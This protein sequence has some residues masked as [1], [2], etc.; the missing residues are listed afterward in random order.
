[1]KF[2]FSKKTHKYYQK[3]LIIVMNNLFFMKKLKINY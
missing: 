1:M 3:K 2:K